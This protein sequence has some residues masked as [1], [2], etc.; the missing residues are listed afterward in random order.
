MFRMFIFFP[1][2]F[3]FEV[4]SVNNRKQR[5]YCAKHQKRCKTSSWFA[6]LVVCWDREFESIKPQYVVSLSASF[7]PADKTWYKSL[8]IF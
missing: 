8:N 5:F 1:I 3:G 4:A 7:L 6:S 2:S